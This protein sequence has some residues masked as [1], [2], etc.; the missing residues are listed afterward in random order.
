MFLPATRARW[1]PVLGYGLDNV[2]E[3]I[4]CRQ[5]TGTTRIQMHL[6]LAL[7][8]I[9]RTVAMMAE[10][11][12][13]TGAGGHAVG[14]AA[15]A[16]AL[17]ARHE[18]VVTAGAGVG[19]VVGDV[20]AWPLKVAAAHESRS[21]VNLRRWG[22]CR[23]RGGAGLR[24]LD[25][26]SGG[27]GALGASATRPPRALDLPGPPG[28]RRSGRWGGGLAVVKGAEV[29]DRNDVLAS[30]GC[31]PCMPCMHTQR[32]QSKASGEGLR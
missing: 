29:V 14:T 20:A 26:A 15:L 1:C 19:V 9:V 10:L 24:G 4:H 5:N 23:R 2:M 18:G 32:F 13:R 28:R 31:R 17:P 12:G 22:W 30:A 8:M 7:R 3:G 27:L 11:E 16:G 21:G 6:A 25:G